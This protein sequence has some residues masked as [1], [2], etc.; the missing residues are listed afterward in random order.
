MTDK[1]AGDWVMVCDK[2]GEVAIGHY[3]GASA[4]AYPSKEAWLAAACA[5][6]FAL[7]DAAKAV[8]AL[9]GQDEGPYLK[10]AAAAIRALKK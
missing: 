1:A 9:P 5:R 4:M 10:Q 7:E 3:C 2:H 6:E 8:E